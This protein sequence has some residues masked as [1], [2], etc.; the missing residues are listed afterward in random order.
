MG[1]MVSQPYH[2]LLKRLFTRGSKKTS[3]LRVTGLCAGNSPVTGEFLA[4]MASNAE[5]ISIWWSHH[6]LEGSAAIAPTNM[7]RSS[8]CHFF[9]STWRQRPPITHCVQ[10]LNFVANCPFERQWQVPHNFEVFVI[11]HVG[12]FSIRSPSWWSFVLGLNRSSL[13][14][15]DVTHHSCANFKCVVT[16]VSKEIINISPCLYVYPM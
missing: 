15:S 2:C 1:S 14:P 9:A 7:S 5:N 13:V 12:M 10:K 11:E 16:D 6:V 8:A 3:K 4:Q